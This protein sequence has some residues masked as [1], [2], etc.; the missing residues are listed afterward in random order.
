MNDD[1]SEYEIYAMRYARK[2]ERRS[3]ENFVEN[4]A[5]DTPMPM[6]FFVWAQAGR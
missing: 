4:D 3:S 1:M 2:D 6:D 5:P